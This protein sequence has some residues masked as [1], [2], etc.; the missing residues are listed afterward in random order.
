[1]L[2][3][4]IR[5]VVL[6]A[7]KLYHA[8]QDEVRKRD[9]NVFQERVRVPAKTKIKMAAKYVGLKLTMKMVAA[10]LALV[11]VFW[12]DS[13]S[14]PFCLL[15][16]VWQFCEHF[17][18][19]GLTYAGFHVI[20]TLPAMALS[21]VLARQTA[22][23]VAPTY[24]KVACAVTAVLCAVATFWTS[25]WDNYLVKAGVWDYPEVG[26]V[27]GVIGY[28]P[29]EEYAFFTIQTVFVCMVWIWQGQCKIIP[30]FR[31][32]GP[33]RVLGL[34]G[35]AAL[36]ASSL[37]MLTTERAFYLGTIIAWSTPVL[38]VQW[39]FGADALA[40]QRSAWM[41]PLIYAVT[42]L[43]LIDRWAIRNGC[44]SIN[45][46]TSLPRVDWLPVEEA[47]F[48]LASSTMCI[49]GLQL[50]MNVFTLDCGF[51]IAVRRVVYWARK[52][53]ASVAFQWTPARLHLSV[54]AL[55]VAASLLFLRDVSVHTQV[56]LMI[57]PS[58]MVG[59]PFGKV[60][61][62]VADWLQIQGVQLYAGAALIVVFT[63]YTCPTL[64]LFVT[65][66]GAM[67][68]FGTADTQG[69]PG[70]VPGID[71]VAR[72]GMMLLAVRYQPEA[73]SWLV[74]QLLSGSPFAAVRAMSSLTTLHLACVLASIAIHM[75]RCHKAHHVEFLLEQLLLTATFLWL[76]PLVSFTLYLNAFYT[77]R[78]LL[79]ASR[80]SAVKGSL[81]Q[82]WQHKS[83][84]GG[85][86]VCL[87]LALVSCAHFF[88]TPSDYPAARAQKPDANLGAFLKLAFVVL[89]AVST[90]SMLLMS[91]RLSR[92]NGFPA[93]SRVDLLPGP[94]MA[95]V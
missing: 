53:E 71:L 65:T 62:V 39:A 2:P 55:L 68:H 89:S 51:A 22:R 61:M 42:Y 58:L 67:Y 72:G 15:F 92:S 43:C 11:T 44:W 76:P 6:V 64:A 63:W 95:A 10:E 85:I 50:A 30:H 93:T 35:L 5:P 40:A 52:E 91:I 84:I 13:M 31:K 81:G 8:L 54:F 86:A 78:Q 82:L 75:M 49:W 74:T 4:R 87:M 57:I 48:F 66:A 41:P 69:R 47:Y 17:S 60:S 19:P 59:L 46:K 3:E 14:T 36:F 77:P 34:T 88:G 16:G 37:W 94:V 33:S 79:L 80:L 21:I 7:S 27:M 29:I 26:H 83:T 18:W 9:Y 20:F 32:A 24:F 12:L 45:M 73:V 25:P 90:P 1:L 56:Y 28:V 23:D 70:N 38:A